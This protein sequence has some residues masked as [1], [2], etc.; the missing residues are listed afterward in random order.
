VAIFHLVEAY[1]NSFQAYFASKL[2]TG[3]SDLYNL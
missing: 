2:I 3:I 1:R